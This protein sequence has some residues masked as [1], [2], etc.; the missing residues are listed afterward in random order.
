MVTL[1]YRVNRLLRFITSVASGTL[2]A[3]A[4]R[5]ADR[6]GVDL[7]FVIRY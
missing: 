4:T 7:I 5:R 2:Q 6:G 3:H 1:E